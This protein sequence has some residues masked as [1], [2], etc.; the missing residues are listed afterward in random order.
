MIRSSRSVMFTGSIPMNLP[1]CTG[2]AMPLDGP[3]NLAEE[4]DDPDPQYGT[5]DELAGCVARVNRWL[6]PRTRPSRC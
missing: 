1:S 3:V 5:D 4:Q 6:G 2:S